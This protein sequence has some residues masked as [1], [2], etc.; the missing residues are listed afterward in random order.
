MQLNSTFFKDD[1]SLKFFYC[2]LNNKEYILLGDKQG[3]IFNTDKCL[4]AGEV[5]MNILYNSEEICNTILHYYKFIENECPADSDVDTIAS[6]LQLLDSELLNINET[7]FSY[8][9]IKQYIFNK[10]V[11]KL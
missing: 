10:Y 2:S 8:F 11:E 1:S 7:F 5:I 9:S 6:Y 3:N 4:P